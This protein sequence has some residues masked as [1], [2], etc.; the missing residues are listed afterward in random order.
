MGKVDVYDILL[1]NIQ[2]DDF[3]CLWN[4]SVVGISHIGLLIYF[5]YKNMILPISPEM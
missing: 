2:K 3:I 1:S 5:S 4:C